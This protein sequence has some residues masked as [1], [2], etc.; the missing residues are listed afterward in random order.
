MSAHKNSLSYWNNSYGN[1]EISLNIIKLD[2]GKIELKLF[3]VLNP[4][5]F[6]ITWD[7]NVAPVLWPPTIKTSFGRGKRFF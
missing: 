2:F 5:L 4:L 6:P 7:R 1:T 3:K